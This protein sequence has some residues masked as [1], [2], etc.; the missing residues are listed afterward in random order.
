MSSYFLYETEKNN[1]QALL[2][3]LIANAENPRSLYAWA[4]SERDLIQRFLRTLQNLEPQ[5]KLL[6]ELT[7]VVSTLSPNDL[8]EVQLFA[9]FLLQRKREE[10]R[11][12][13]FK[14]ARGILADHKVER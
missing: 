2:E 13:G 12:G 3:E 11:P 6:E 5:S 9:E 7:I 8:R 4:L 10:S 14:R 1:L